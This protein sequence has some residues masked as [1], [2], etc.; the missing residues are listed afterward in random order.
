MGLSNQLLILQVLLPSFGE[1]VEIVTLPKF[2][3]SPLKKLPGQ[4]NRKPDLN[5]LPVPPFVQG[6]LLMVQK[7]HSQP[8]GIQKKK[9]ANNG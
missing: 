2:N 8:T 6:L 1:T 4:P 9:L 7:S 5:L 3:S